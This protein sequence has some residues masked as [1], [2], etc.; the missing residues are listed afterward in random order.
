MTAHFFKTSG[1]CHPTSQ[2]HVMWTLYLSSNHMHI[3][4]DWYS[5]NSAHE[6]VYSCRTPRTFLPV[7]LERMIGSRWDLLR[8]HRLF[9]QVLCMSNLPQPQQM[10]LIGTH[11][12]RAGRC[13]TAGPE[14]F[15]RTCG[16][17][18][19]Q[20]WQLLIC[21]LGATWRTEC[22]RT[23]RH[24]S[25]ERQV[26]TG[27]HQHWERRSAANGGQHA[28]LCL[29]VSSWGRLQFSAFD[30]K[31]SSSAWIRAYVTIVPFHSVHALLNYKP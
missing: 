7:I 28:T 29:D 12:H 27:G 11:F 23:S 21:F 15:Q 19:H 5:N 18:D 24:T 26:P 31:S 2:R 22:T 17:L 14:S 8:M 20:T 3:F 4:G 1:T 9:I 16:H 6:G 30:I 13:C 25:L 10:A